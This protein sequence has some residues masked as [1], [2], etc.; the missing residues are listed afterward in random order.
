MS[1]VTTRNGM[2]WKPLRLPRLTVCDIDDIDTTTATEINNHND[3][4]ELTSL[5]KVLQEWS[6]F[7]ISWIRLQKHLQDT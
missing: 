4:K 5:R 6:T 2:M 1:V 7:R 3:V